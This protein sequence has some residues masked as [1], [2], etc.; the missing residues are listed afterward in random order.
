[1]SDALDKLFATRSITPETLNAATAAIGNT[2]AALRAAHLKYHLETLDLLEMLQQKTKGNLQADEER[3]F[4]ALLTDL[5]LK[6]L[7][8]TRQ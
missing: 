5:R 7:Q 4:Q 6:Y 8:K 1:M 2:N 3:L